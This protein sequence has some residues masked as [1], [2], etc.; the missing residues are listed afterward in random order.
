MYGSL[1]YALAVALLAAGIYALGMFGSIGQGSLLAGRRINL[2][3][4]RRSLAEQFFESGAVRRYNDRRISKEIYEGL[5][6]LR[7]LAAS[8]ADSELSADCV[9]LRLSQKKGFLQETYCRMLSLLRLNKLAEAEKCLADK[10]GLS[11]GREYADILVSWDFINPADIKEIIISYQKSIR[12]IN[13]TTRRKREEMI[14][15]LAYFPAVFNI[16]IIFVNFI[17]T[18]YF[19][20]QKELLNMIF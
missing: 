12:E 7:N 5:S 13:A 1:I 11:I 19:S 15:D 14:S 16:L 6:L 20:E 9:I 10:C 4:P 8:G 2:S 17:Y 3:R 18:G